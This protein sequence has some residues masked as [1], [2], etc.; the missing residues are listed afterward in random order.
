MPEL[1]KKL[2]ISSKVELKAIIRKLVTEKVKQEQIMTSIVEEKI[3][4]K[5]VE[6]YTDDG[7]SVDG[8]TE[9]AQG[10]LTIAGKVREIVVDRGHDKSLSLRELTKKYSITS[11]KEKIKLQDIYLIIQYIQIL[12]Y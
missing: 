1:F 2:L 4:R 6:N 5:D 8:D 3:Q 10:E 11:Q 9:I 12:G 7:I